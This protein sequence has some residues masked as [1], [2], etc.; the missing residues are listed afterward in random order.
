MPLAR[1]E[2]DVDLNGEGWGDSVDW[3]NCVFKATALVDGKTIEAKVE[4]FNTLSD[5]GTPPVFVAADILAASGAGKPFDINGVVSDS[6]YEIKV[7]EACDLQVLHFD[8][9]AIKKFKGNEELVLTSDNNGNITGFFALGNPKT[10]CELALKVGDWKD[11]IAADSTTA[12]QRKDTDAADELQVFEIANHT[13][14]VKD[15]STDKD[16]MAINTGGTQDAAPAV[17]KGRVQPYFSNDNGATWVKQ[18]EVEVAKWKDLA[19]VSALTFDKSDSKRSHHQ[20]LLKVKATYDGSDSEWWVYLGNSYRGTYDFYTTPTVSKLFRIDSSF[21][22]DKKTTARVVESCNTRVF[23]FK[24]QFAEKEYGH[25]GGDG[26]ADAPQK[27]T[28]HLKIGKIVELGRAATEIELQEGYHVTSYLRGF[29]VGEFPR[30]DQ[31][32]T[33]RCGIV[34]KIEQEGQMDGVFVQIQTNDRKATTMTLSNS[35]GKIAIAFAGTPS[36]LHSKM[37]MYVSN[38]GG[39]TW[40]QHGSKGDWPADKATVTTKVDW[41]SDAKQNLVMI[42]T[43]AHSDSNDNFWGPQW[44]Y[45]EGKASTD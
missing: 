37:E 25:L 10:D 5:D 40:T 3:A 22:T 31:Y 29:T 36:Y 45:A 34:L 21:A 28:M 42:K 24:E 30:A 13:E 38:D 6:H 8:G 41:N 32:G 27:L 23:Y 39:A 11:S 20:A 17:L 16:L 4:G 15:I 18:P 33:P 43:G 26:T 2:F 19:N 35:S 44:A 1:G 9:A 14:V 12:P 7:T